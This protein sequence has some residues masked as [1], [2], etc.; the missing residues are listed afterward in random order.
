MAETN[1]PQT[2]DQYRARYEKDN[3]ELK[4]VSDDV[5]AEKVFGYLKEQGV[6]NDYEAFI[7]NFIPSR[8]ENTAA[9]YRQKYEKDNPDLKKLTDIELAN[10]IFD[11]RKAAG[12][13]LN[14]GEFLDKFTP[15]QDDTTFINIPGGDFLQVGTP[16]KRTTAEIAKAAGID[17][18]SDVS[19]TPAR[20]AGSLAI[21]EA[22]QIQAYKNVMSN[23]F[24]QEVDVRQGPKTGELEFFN[25]QNKKYQLFN[26]PGLDTGDFASFGGD[27][28]VIVP[29]IA[30]TVFVASAPLTG[31]ASLAAAATYVADLI[32]VG[33]GQELYGINLDAKGIQRFTESAPEGFISGTATGVG[34]SVPK[35]INLL[36]SDFIILPTEHAIS[37][38]APVIKIFID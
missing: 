8:P 18:A 35:I 33:M 21:N 23:I 32:R 28:L 1:I 25:P 7:Y 9:G 31:G 17:L 30:A 15:K 3:P 4:N 6:A 13:K 16:T 5:I 11:K 26:K 20:F 36:N 37:P 10:R 34:V 19:T 29:D 38:W 24:G 14:Y 2:V 22:E 12:E 27:A